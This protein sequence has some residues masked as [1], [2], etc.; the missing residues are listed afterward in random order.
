MWEEL[1]GGLIGENPSS[2]D[3]KSYFDFLEPA[4]IMMCEVE[5]QTMRKETMEKESQSEEKEQKEQ[6]LQVD[7]QELNE[8]IVNMREKRNKKEEKKEETTT[9]KSGNNLPA[10]SATDNNKTEI[11]PQVIPLTK[12]PIAP[13]SA[14]DISIPITHPENKEDLVNKGKG[15]KDKADKEKADK[16]DKDKGDK[17][18]DD[19]DKGDQENKEEEEDIIES[20]D[21]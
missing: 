19:I 9:D 20:L 5:S 8:Y 3:I 16:E 13:L 12:S 14:G 17:D 7:I 18:K 4:K 21:T 10:P 6:N 1:A 2:G 11:V 15:D